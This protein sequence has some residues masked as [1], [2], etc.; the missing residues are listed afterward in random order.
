VQRWLHGADRALVR[1][2]AARFEQ[3]RRATRPDAESL[4]QEETAARYARDAIE[5]IGAGEDGGVL[6]A[7]RE[8]HWLEPHVVAVLELAVLGLRQVAVSRASERTLSE[9]RKRGKVRAHTTV[10]TRFHA[11]VTAS[12]LLRQV[13][14]WRVQTPPGTVK[15]G[16]T[17]T[18]LAAAPTP[19][20]AELVTAG[21]LPTPSGDLSLDAPRNI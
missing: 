1:L 11:T 4:R 8:R 10:P 9:L 12:E 14:P 20:L 17:Q 15:Q 16:R 3:I 5:R 2:P 13:D 19:K 18:W 7:W 6:P 21:P